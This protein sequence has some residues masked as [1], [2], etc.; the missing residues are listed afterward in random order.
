MP[1]DRK[2]TRREV[3]SGTN[4]VQFRARPDQLTQAEVAALRRLLERSAAVC[5]ACPIARTAIREA[6]L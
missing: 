3:D 4:V 6:G 2:E 5:Q 1:Q